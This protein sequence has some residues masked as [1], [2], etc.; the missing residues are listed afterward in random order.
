MEAN[1]R[2]WIWREFLKGLR[3]SLADRADRFYT[4]TT[5]W[6]LGY[7]EFLRVVVGG[8]PRLQRGGVCV[9]WNQGSC[10]EHDPLAS[11][12]RPVGAWKCCAA[13]IC[14]CRRRW[15]GRTERRAEFVQQEGLGFLLRPQLSVANF[16][17]VFIP[18]RVVESASPKVRYFKGK[19]LI[20]ILVLCWCGG[21]LFYWLAS[22]PPPITGLHGHFPPGV[23]DRVVFEK[24][25]LS[26]ERSVMQ[27]QAEVAAP[28]RM[29]RKLK[30]AWLPFFPAREELISET[31]WYSSSPLPAAFAVSTLFRS[32]QPTAIVVY[33]QTNSLLAATLWQRTFAAIHTSAPLVTNITMGVPP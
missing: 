20:L 15:V 32:N 11:S 2:Q 29:L 25:G 30:V 26:P 13:G 3:R 6:H 21:A 8:L 33:A 14:G 24:Y 1:L 23:A 19:Y 12:L 28:W 18:S 27:T 5:P 17:A 10:R 31:H 9:G 22:R 4:G 16:F 7:V